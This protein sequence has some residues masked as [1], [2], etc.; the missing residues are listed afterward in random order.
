M[1]MLTQADMATPDGA[2]V[3][4]LLRH[5]GAA[6]QQRVSGPDL[7]HAYCAH[8]AASGEAVFLLGS[9]PATLQR[10]QAR[11]R[12]HWPAL[13][14]A[15]ALSPPFRPLSDDEDRAIVQAIQA[16]GAGTVWVSLGCPKQEQWMAAHR[17]SIG[18]VQI[19][20][21]AA[22]D[23][24]AGTLR[25]APVWMQLSGLEWLHRLASEPGRLWK[26]YLWTNTAFIWGAV[27][28]VCGRT[29]GHRP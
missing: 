16:S 17:S 4:W 20:V 3:A 13:R 2:P 6:G 28:Q 1:Q 29:P 10:L 8:A 12:D 21:G 15:G 23:F 5:Q 26:R 7:M 22:F 9:T 11:L 24:H 25:R 18:A 27:R 19:G 14:I